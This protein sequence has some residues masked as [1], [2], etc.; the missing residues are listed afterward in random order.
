MDNTVEKLNNISLVKSSLIT[1]LI[2]R[3]ERECMNKQLTITIDLEKLTSD[4][5]EKETYVKGNNVYAVLQNEVKREIKQNIHD[6]VVREIT[7]NL[8]ISELKEQGMS[9]A[10]LTRT[11]RELLDEELR[12][13]VKEVVDE[14]VKNNMRRI[15]ED[16]ANKTIREF[17]VPRLEKLINSLIIINTESAEQEMKELENYYEEQLQQM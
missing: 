4:I 2:C 11:A 13:L 15:I 16:Q 17:L 12:S 7:Q 9:K 10:W 1:S 14:F 3:L 6:G 8:N 5:L